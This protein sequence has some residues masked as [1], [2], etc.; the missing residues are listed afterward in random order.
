MHRV[1][2]LLTV[3]VLAAAC[4]DPE[5][6]PDE[7]S[8]L[9]HDLVDGTDLEAR[10][11]AHKKLPEHG[12]LIVY[13]LGKALDRDDVDDGVGA[14]IAETLG[15][16][17]ARARAAAPALGR[18][19]RRG[20]E[21]AATTSWALGQMGAAG[22]PELIASMA[23]KH[24]KT[25]LWASDA[26]SNVASEIGEKAVGAREALVAALDDGVGEVRSNALSGLAWL[27]APSPDV[28]AAIIARISDT[29]DMAAVSALEAVQFLGLWNEAD[30]QTRIAALLQ[31]TDE[32]HEDA[33]VRARELMRD[34]ADK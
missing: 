14:W 21:C 34:E 22:L 29:N 13:P 27:G 31:T 10:M 33:R 18:R 16:L 5:P 24:D 20:G 2:L 12:A 19:L 4:G 26:I 6:L 9:I 15:A 1:V 17:G 8:A 3:A 23:S 7:V 28:A 30:A 25:R 11:A 32:N